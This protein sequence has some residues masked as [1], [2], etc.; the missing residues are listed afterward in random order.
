[1][2]IETVEWMKALLARARGEP[3][4]AFIS[5]TSAADAYLRKEPSISLVRVLWV[6][7]E[8]ALD[9]AE[10]AANEGESIRTPYVDAV[11][12]YLRLTTEYADKVKDPAGVEMATLSEARAMQVDR[13]SSKVPANRVRAMLERIKKSRDWDWALEVDAYTTLGRLLT[14]RELTAEAREAFDQAARIADEHHAP[15][16][17]WFARNALGGSSRP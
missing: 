6:A 1:M 15:G 17:A 2:T 14:I 7:T 9:L 11:Q 4:R 5:V 10:D 12:R 3:I 16:M 8:V 13:P